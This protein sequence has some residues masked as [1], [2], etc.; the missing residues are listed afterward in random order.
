MRRWR[1][2]GEGA[3][4]AT[5]H[6]TYLNKLLHT[7]ADGDIIDVGLLLGGVLCGKVGKLGLG[8]GLGVGSNVWCGH[9]GDATNT[10]TRRSRELQE[11]ARVVFGGHLGHGTAIAD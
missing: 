7:L 1:S 6:L 2:E 4:F 3:E 10:A 8:N 9:G 11:S 5:S